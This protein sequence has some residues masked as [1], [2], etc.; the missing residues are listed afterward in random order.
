MSQIFFVLRHGERADYAQTQRVTRVEGDPPLTE[1]GL[2]QAVVAAG[3]VKSWMKENGKVAV[4]S[5]PF[6]RCIE[7][8]APLAKLL[9]VPIIVEEGF[10]EMMSPKYFQDGILDRVLSKSQTHVL[11]DEL[12][13]K[14]VQGL[15]VLRPTFPETWANSSTRARNVW[16]E[17]KL[18]YKEF[19]YVVI[20]TH[21]FFVDTFFEIWTNIVNY[22]DDGFCKLGVCEMFEDR[23]I[24][25]MTPSSCYLVDEKKE[26]R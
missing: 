16:N 19:K 8:A 2:Q 25:L 11:E 12:D 22:Q 17:F 5:S 20:V 24:C 1:V 6:T 21:L 4:F 9:D 23:N 14:I 18:R 10:S 7:T 26:D 3:H 15:H 13:V